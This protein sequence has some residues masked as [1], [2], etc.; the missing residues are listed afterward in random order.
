MSNCEPLTNFFLSGEW[1]KEV[2]VDNP[3][4]MQGGIRSPPLKGGKERV[5]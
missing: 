3:L 2:N 4:G 5:V 1:E